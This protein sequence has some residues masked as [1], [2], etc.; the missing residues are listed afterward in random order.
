MF[1]IVNLSLFSPLKSREKRGLLQNY[2]TKLLKYL[3]TRVFTFEIYPFLKSD[4]IRS[5]LFQEL[6]REI[7]KTLNLQLYYLSSIINA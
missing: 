3:I 5:H 7:F 4:L 1:F 6:I 2:E